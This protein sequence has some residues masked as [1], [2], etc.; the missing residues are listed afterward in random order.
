MEA[1]TEIKPIYVN[2]EIVPTNLRPEITKPV[3]PCCGSSIKIEV[4]PS[5]HYRQKVI[6]VVP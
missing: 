5:S 1:P 2:P 3:Q 6:S 4:I